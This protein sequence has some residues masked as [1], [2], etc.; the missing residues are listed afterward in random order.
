VGGSEVAVEGAAPAKT[1]RSTSSPPACPASA[2]G[3]PGPACVVPCMHPAR[4]AVRLWKRLL[5][6][7]AARLE[8]S[9]VCTLGMEESRRARVMTRSIA[10]SLA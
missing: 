1:R 7:A 6:C 4:G 2:A 3:P 8:P 5:S 9:R 10:A